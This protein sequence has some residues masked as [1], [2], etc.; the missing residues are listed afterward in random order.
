MS[1]TVAGA[2]S[3]LAELGWEVLVGLPLYH[4]ARLRPR[5]PDRSKRK[6]EAN[7]ATNCSR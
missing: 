1:S 5:A 6:I 3:E 2:A 4:D 7:N